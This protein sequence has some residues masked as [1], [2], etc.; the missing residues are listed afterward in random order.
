MICWLGEHPAAAN[1]LPPV[2]STEVQ[3]SLL[4]FRALGAPGSDG[5]MNEVLR[6]TSAV[7]LPFVTAIAQSSIQ[8]QYFPCAWKRAIAVPVPKAGC[9]LEEAGGYQPISLLSVLGKVVEYL[10]TKRLTFCLES[11]KKLSKN[12]FG[13]RK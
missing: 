13:F 2:S 3:T 9:D 11:G 1:E 5:I 8:L 4:H 6:R 10:V 7:S 12:Q